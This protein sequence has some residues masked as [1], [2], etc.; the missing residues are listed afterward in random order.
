[1]GRNLPVE[2]AKKVVLPFSAGTDFERCTAEE[3]LRI[4]AARLLGGQCFEVDRFHR[5]RGG[6]GV[7]DRL[8]CRG[9]GAGQKIGNDV[10]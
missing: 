7:P 6:S 10:F 9:N 5:R 4:W 2:V 3:A 8:R 1:M